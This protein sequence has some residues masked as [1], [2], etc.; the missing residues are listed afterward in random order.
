MGRKRNSQVRRE[1]DVKKSGKKLQIKC[2]HCGKE[3]KSLNANAT[4]LKSH[5]KACAQF[6]TKLVDGQSDDD[7]DVT[8][9]INSEDSMSNSDIEIIDQPGTSNSTSTLGKRNLHSDWSNSSTPKSTRST[10]SK[11]PA[12]IQTMFTTYVQSNPL[13]QS[14]LRLVSQTSDTEMLKFDR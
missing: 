9:A 8:S 11:Q 5:L 6:K 3:W 12:A 14:A 4:R 2:K 1:Y 13:K 7:K 10:C